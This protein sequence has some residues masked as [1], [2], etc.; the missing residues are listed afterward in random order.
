M[1]LWFLLVGV[2]APLSL[3]SLK[4]RSEWRDLLSRSVRYWWNKAWA[5]ICPGIKKARSDIDAITVSP[6]TSLTSW[7]QLPSISF[8]I[9]AFRAEAVG[10]L[11][12]PQ[13]LTEILR[14]S[15]WIFWCIM[16]RAI[17]RLVWQDDANV[18]QHLGPANAANSSQYLSMKPS[19]SFSFFGPKT[20]GTHWSSWMW[21]E[22]QSSKGNSGIHNYNQWHKMFTIFN[23]M[24][25]CC[26]LVHSLTLA[27]HS[28][29]A[30][31]LCKFVCLL[32][33]P[34][35]PLRPSPV[36]RWNMVKSS[37]PCAVIHIA[38]STNLTYTD[39]ALISVVKETN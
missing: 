38:C 16:A 34:G 12:M 7:S 32:R 18:T 31:L 3:P 25:S 35:G 8:Q 21:C 24:E 27:V 30:H 37:Q 1:Q 9:Q 23:V 20:G 17:K 28:S 13:I 6:L 4:A 22:S 2:F 19:S 15:L 5:W 10:Q 11:C 29:F 14:C 39:L 36:S 33:H 26:I